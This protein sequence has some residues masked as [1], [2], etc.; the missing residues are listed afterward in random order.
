MGEETKRESNERTKPNQEGVTNREKTVGKID[1][2][3]GPERHRCTNTPKQIQRYKASRTAVTLTL[4]TFKFLTIEDFQNHI[5]FT[6]H[7][8]GIGFLGQV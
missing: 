5:T 4:P 1:P 6:Y 8:L 2:H 7:R 3:R